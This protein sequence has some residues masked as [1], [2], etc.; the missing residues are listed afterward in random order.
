MP[1]ARR[2]IERDCMECGKTI[3]ITVYKDDTYE[4]GHYF[5]KFTVRDETAAENIK[6]Q[7]NGKNTIWLNGLKKR[8]HMSIGSA[9]TVFSSR[10]TD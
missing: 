3:E 1:V 8:I 4:G 7:A 9:T 2:I 10:Q 5:G 6:R